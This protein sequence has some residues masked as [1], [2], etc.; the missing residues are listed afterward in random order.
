[1][2]EE[3]SWA[4]NPLLGDVCAFCDEQSEAQVGGGRLVVCWRH[5]QLICD[6]ERDR[7]IVE[8]VLAHA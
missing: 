3:Y 5:F 4:K 1:M 6:G 7:A 2:N 8:E